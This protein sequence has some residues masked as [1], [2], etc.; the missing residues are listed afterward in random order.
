MAG[1]QRFVLCIV[2]LL[3]PAAASG[4]VPGATLQIEPQEILVDL[5]YSG[6]DIR[7]SGKAPGG[8]GLVVLCTGEERTVELKQKGKAWGLFWLN[9]G[10]INFNHVP[11][12][13]Q[14]AS[15]KKLKDLDSDADLI[16]AGIGFPALEARAAPNRSEQHHELFMELMKLKEHEGLYSIQEGQLKTD[17][18]EGQ[19]RSY[20]TSFHFPASAGSGKYTIRL[21]GFVEGKAVTLASERLPV[22]LAGAAA[23][24]KSLSL[25]HGLLYGIFAVVIALAAGLLTG[26]VFGRRAPKGGH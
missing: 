14:L 23:L 26:L 15:S 7:I 4:Q 24:I 10:D 13:Y 19:E 5:F 3:V 25:E 18:P 20:S 22:R 11:D 16:R 21:I 17:A 2:L 8:E 6:A 12:L 9:V 1:A